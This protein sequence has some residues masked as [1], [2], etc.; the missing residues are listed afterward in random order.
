MRELRHYGTN[1]IQLI[2]EKLDFQNPTIEEFSSLRV[3][4]VRIDRAET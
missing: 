1:A 4:G 2:E 3:S